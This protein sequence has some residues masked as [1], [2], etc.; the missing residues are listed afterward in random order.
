MNFKSGSE[1]TRD[2]YT[3][4][5]SGIHQNFQNSAKIGN[6]GKFQNNFHKD[7]PMMNF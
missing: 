1:I 3:W 7:E 2:N 6:F 5:F 4:V